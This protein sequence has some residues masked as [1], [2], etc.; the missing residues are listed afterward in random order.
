MAL[1]PGQPG[2]QPTI[3]DRIAV[4]LGIAVHRIACVVIM[5]M[6]AL[7]LATTVHACGAKLGMW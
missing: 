2:Y 1:R 4:V 6:V 5:L 7:V 3:Y